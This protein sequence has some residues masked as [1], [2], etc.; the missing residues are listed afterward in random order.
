VPRLRPLDRLFLV[1]SVVLAALF[2]RLGVWQMHRRAER[3]ARNAMVVDR[4]SRPTLTLAELPRDTASA[5]YTTVR[6]VGVYDFAHEIALVN[7]VRDGAPGVHLI[8]PVRTAGA[9]TAVLVDRG[10]VY[11]PDAETVDRAQWRE[12]ADVDAVGYVQELPTPEHGTVSLPGH[13]TQMRWLDPA[14]IA[15][16]TGYPVTPYYVALIEDSA[17]RARAVAAHAPARILP[18]PLDD[19]PHLSY[20]IQ[21]FAFAL[22]AIVGPVV[23]I[24]GVERKSVR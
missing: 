19:G 5:H 24:F 23:A 7:R 22:I 11:A 12:S 18:P 10:W 15:Q 8:T 4:L 1:L 6:V 20:A 3:R 17:S 16:L 14:A 21:W 9:D 2:A 13:P